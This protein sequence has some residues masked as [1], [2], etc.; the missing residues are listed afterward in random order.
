MLVADA[1]V[2]AAISKQSAAIAFRSRLTLHARAQTSFLLDAPNAIA[3][4][5]QQNLPITPHCL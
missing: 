3:C 4:L 5:P 2:G 1:T